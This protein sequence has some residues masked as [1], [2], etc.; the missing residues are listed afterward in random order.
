[1]ETDEI[2]N[3]TVITEAEKEVY[4]GSFSVYFSEFYKAAELGI[5]CELGL[6]ISEFDD[7]GA[8]KVRYNDKT[9]KV[10]RAAKRS[11][12]YEELYL[13]ELTHE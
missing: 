7:N 5:K 13:E 8:T 1:V 9:Y 11:D 4:C 12:H 3:D 10:Y 2:G 6:I